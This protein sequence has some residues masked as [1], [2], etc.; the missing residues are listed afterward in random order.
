M[1]NETVMLLGA[2]AAIFLPLFNIPLIA[3]MIRRKSSADI[4]LW[5]ALG[6]WTCLVL[7]L[8]AGLGSSD[9]VFK[10]F[11]VVNI[12]FFSVVVAVTVFYRKKDHGR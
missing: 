8:P 12:V 1:T 5:W 7:M 11:N 10:I 2:A 4:S 6:V 3:R 9:L